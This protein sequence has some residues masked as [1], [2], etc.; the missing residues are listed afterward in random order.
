MTHPVYLVLPLH[1]EES[2]RGD[3]YGRQMLKTQRDSQ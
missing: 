1:R 2:S 3:S